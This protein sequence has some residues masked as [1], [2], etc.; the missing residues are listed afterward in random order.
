[1]NTSY[2]TDVVAWAN[3][4]ASLLRASRFDKLE[5]SHIAEEIKDVGK[6]EQR[7]WGR[8]MAVL[9]AHILKW[10]FQPEWSVF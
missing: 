10:K 6:R 5:L 1:M 2:K 4:Q 3:E 8:R 7:E 9:L